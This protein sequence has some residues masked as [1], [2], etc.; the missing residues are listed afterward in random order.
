MMTSITD[1]M[2]ISFE[3]S[4]RPVRF[5]VIASIAFLLLV[6]AWAASERKLAAVFFA[7]TQ[8]TSSEAN[9]GALVK[10]AAAGRKDVAWVG[11]SL[12]AALSERY[13]TIPHSYN[14]GLSGG[15]PVT[16]LEILERLPSLPK[17]VIV[18]TNIL[19]RPPDSS[20]LQ[21]PWELFDNPA[22]ALLSDFYQPLQLISAAIVFRPERIRLRAQA[23]RKALLEEPSSYRGLSA[24][25]RG[26][27]AALDKLPVNDGLE[28]SNAARLIAA[29]NRLLAR[30]VRR[31]RCRSG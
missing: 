2:L 9:L 27:L 19:D 21:R 31:R 5:I 13:F 25:A 7:P 6:A 29:K 11:S 20:L 16:G 24:S 1:P 17:A 18:E 23:R 4:E 26:A 28:T 22:V 15:S 10:Y 3:R 8:L 12:T 30:G 14:L